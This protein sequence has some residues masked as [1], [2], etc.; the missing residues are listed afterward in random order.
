MVPQEPITPIIVEQVNA[1][2]R[3]V[4]VID[5]LLSA[6]GLLGVI[7]IAAALF[8]GLLGALLIWVRTHRTESGSTGRATDYGFKL[9]Y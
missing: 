9:S 1:P 6:V 3:P 2:A 4:T 8:G 7:L 5:V